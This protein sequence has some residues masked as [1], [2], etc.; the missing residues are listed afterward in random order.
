[1]IQLTIEEKNAIYVKKDFPL[2]MSSN[3]NKVIRSV[4]NFSFFYENILQAQKAQK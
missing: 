3:I 2:M 1:M 4:L